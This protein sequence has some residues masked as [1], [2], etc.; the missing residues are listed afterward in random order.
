VAKLENNW[1][2]KS[3]EA[4]ENNNWGDAA[5]APTNLV[6]RCIELSKVPV[7]NFTTSDLRLMI[8]Q[9]FG[10]QFLIP[11]AL[12]KLQ[13]DVFLEA[14]FYEGDLLSNI[15]NVD[16]SF[17][18]DNESIWTA[19]SKLIN[20]KQQELADRKIVTTKFDNAKFVAKKG[21]H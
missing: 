7:G 17:W 11:L 19:L 21:S 15:L 10:L 9:K 3:L 6:K 8:G 16:T 14:D 4:L 13:D 12:E 5:N 18:N 20:D 1:R 2:Q